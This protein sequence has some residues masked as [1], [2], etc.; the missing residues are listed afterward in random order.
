LKI[1][2]GCGFESTI[3]DKQNRLAIN[4]LCQ[5]LSVKQWKLIY[6]ASRDGFTE[7][8]FHGKCDGSANTLTIIKSTNGNIFGGFTE[9]AWDSTSEYLID[10]KAFIFS[11]VNKENKTF[12]VMCKNGASAIYCGSAFGPIFGRCNDIF[13]SSGSNANQTSHSNFGHT[14]KHADYQNGTTK[15][16][17]IL[18]GSRN[19]KSK[20]LFE[21]TNFFNIF[22]FLIFDHNK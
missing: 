1:K 16:N 8:N 7:Q 10:S 17:S 5:F 21:Q 14:Y 12:K 22:I 4:N 19:L 18:A 2:P 9:K 13:I 15:A 11:L 20:Y 6:R 3:L